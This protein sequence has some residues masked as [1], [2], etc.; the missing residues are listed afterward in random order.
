MSDGDGGALQAATR[1]EAPE[2]RG[3]RPAQLA[4]CR[5]FGKWS[6]STPISEMIPQALTRSTPGIV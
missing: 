6:M 4:R 3:Q 2:E 1:G 5:A